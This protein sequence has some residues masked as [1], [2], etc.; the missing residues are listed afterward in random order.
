MQ[1][2]SRGKANPRSASKKAQEQQQAVERAATA[3]PAV[4]AP[5]KPQA[6]A[7]GPSFTQAQPRSSA[8]PRSTPQAVVDRMFKRMIACAGIPV[9]TGILLLV[10]F[11]YLKASSGIAALANS[12]GRHCSCASPGKGLLK[13]HSPP[14]TG[15]WNRLVALPVD[16]QEGS[17]LQAN[18]CLSPRYPGAQLSAVLITPACAAVACHVQVVQKVEF[19]MWIVYGSQN[20]MFGGGLLGITYGIMSTSWDPTRE[21]SVSQC[22]RVPT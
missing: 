17:V 2:S 16:C 3:P 6:P 9:A 15:S 22:Q 14:V 20:L 13:W 19:P 8:V 11:Y 18:A 10:M 7:T 4:A 12:P 21:G 1:V 5:P